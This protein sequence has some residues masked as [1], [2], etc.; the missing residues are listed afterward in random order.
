[1][2][3]NGALQKAIARDPGQSVV[4][5]TVADVGDL[6][7][8][9]GRGFKR[10]YSSGNLVKNKDTFGAPERVGNLRSVEGVYMRNP[11]NNVW[12]TIS[13]FPAPKP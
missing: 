5:V 9:L 8:D 10:V 4:R 2:R 7:A 1:M 13:I 11:K 12:E 6:G 3:N